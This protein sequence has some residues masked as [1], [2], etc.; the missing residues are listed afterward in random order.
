MLGLSCVKDQFGL[1][2]GLFL[3]GYLLLK[4]CIMLNFPGWMGGW[5]G[6]VGSSGNKVNSALLEL[7]LCLAKIAKLMTCLLPATCL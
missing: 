7:G 4:L 6:V 2:K 3:C 5:R 1:A